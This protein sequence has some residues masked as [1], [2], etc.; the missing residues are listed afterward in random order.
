MKT[1]V[2]FVALINVETRK[3]YVYQ[4]PN[5]KKQTI[6]EIFNQWIKDIPK[7]QHSSAIS[8]DLGSEFNSK[9]FYK[10]LEFKEI[11]LLDRKSLIIKPLI[12]QR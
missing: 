2:K 3:A 9:D 11:K 6:I 5:L 4:I 8:S 12:Q 7:D 10:W 1:Q